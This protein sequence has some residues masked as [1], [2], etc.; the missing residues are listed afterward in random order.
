MEQYIVIEE[1]SL[2]KFTKLVNKKILQGY[3]P[4]GGI[5]VAIGGAYIQALLL[6]KEK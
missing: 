6:K 4:Q 1:H 2:S 5:S 3:I